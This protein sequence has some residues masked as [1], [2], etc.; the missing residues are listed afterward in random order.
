MHLRTSSLDMPIMYDWA[1][2]ATCARCKEQAASA[3]QQS[4]MIAGLM[5]RTTQLAV[6]YLA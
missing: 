5:K 2:C 6:S 4:K 1:S 3:E